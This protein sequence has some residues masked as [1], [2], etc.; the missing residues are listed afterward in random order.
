MSQGYPRTFIDA[1]TVQTAELTASIQDYCDHFC[2]TTPDNGSETLQLLCEAGGVSF[3][4]SVIDEP[5]R[6]LGG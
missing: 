1:P 3:D 4:D 2:Q 6:L 5:L